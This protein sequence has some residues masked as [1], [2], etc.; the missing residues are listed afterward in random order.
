MM[1]QPRPPRS[2]PPK[3]SCRKPRPKRPRLAE[4]I[5]AEPSI[6]SFPRGPDPGT[7]LHGLLEWAAEQ[8]FAELIRDHHRCENQVAVYCQRRN[9][10]DWAGVMQ[11]WMQH[12]LQTPLLL[13]H[14]QGE[15]A[16]GSLASDGY[17]AELE[18]MLAVHRVDT[19]VLDETINRFVLPGADA[20]RVDPRS[21]Q[22]HGKRLYRSGVLSPRALLRAGLQ[23]QPLRGEPAGL[24]Q[25]GH[26]GSR[27]GTPLRSAIRA[28]YAGASPPVKSPPA[29][30]Q[31]P[32]PYGR[33]ALPVPQGR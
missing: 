16:M 21:S 23:I 25:P 24:Q 22:R 13:P 3:R 11:P 14:D 19:R 30:L 32:A 2:R 9:W 4:T 6:H 28:L 29:G 17:Q 33:R 7:F 12:L 5:R 18:F 10:G 26:G 1:R 8:G 15:V 27:S 31:L 20:S